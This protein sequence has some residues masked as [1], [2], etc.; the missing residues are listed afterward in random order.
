MRRSGK[1]TRHVRLQYITHIT[2][3]L[4]STRCTSTQRA[5][6]CTVLY[7][8]YVVLRM[9]TTMLQLLPITKRAYRQ[10][11]AILD[12]LTRAKY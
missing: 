3:G 7:D 10:L 12:P 11:A 6:R 5:R 1:E 4:S 2:L 9:G 8:G